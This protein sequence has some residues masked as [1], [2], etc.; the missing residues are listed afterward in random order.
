MATLDEAVK[1]F[2]AQKRLAV[3]GVSRS[4]KE[5]ANFIYRKLRKA[6]YEVFPV[7]P[8]T[9][10]IEGDN[11]FPSVGS[12]PGGVDGA[13]IATHPTVCGRIV[14]E[15]AEASIPRVWIHRSFGQGSLSEEALRIGREKHV[16]VIPG[17]C[18][19][20]FCKPDIAH[21]CMRWV[22]KMTGGLPE[23]V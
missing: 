17:G 11:C 6:G 12:I 23:E 9:Q 4:S 8:N 21:R 2:L 18:P 10:E 19:A 5:A 7:N 1:E 20:M 3:V 22:L 13:V 14:Q 16:T 15:C